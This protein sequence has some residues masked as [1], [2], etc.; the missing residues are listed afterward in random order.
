LEVLQSFHAALHP[1]GQALLV[2][3]KILVSSPFTRAAYCQ[4]LLIKAAHKQQ[5]KHSMSTQKAC[6]ITAL[7]YKGSNT[8]RKNK[9]SRSASSSRKL[10]VGIRIEE[11]LY[12]SIADMKQS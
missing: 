1:A 12:F 11:M 5:R 7:G 8:E 10:R 6:Y 9:A 2:H 3:S 4:S